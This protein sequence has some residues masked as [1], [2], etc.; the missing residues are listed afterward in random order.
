MPENTINTILKLKRGTDTSWA[1]SIEILKEGEPG[2]DKINNILKIGNG[3][4]IWENLPLIG[5]KPESFEQFS[6]DNHNALFSGYYNIKGSKYCHILG[7]IVVNNNYGSLPQSITFN[8]PV[9]IEANSAPN[10]IMSYAYLE[11]D[12]S[13]DNT[14]KRGT[15]YLINTINDRNI[16]QLTHPVDGQTIT[17]GTFYVD[18]SYNLM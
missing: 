14:I 2:Y 9:P 4:D 16:L 6:L 11:A 1:E 12:D 7:K 18:F 17:P 8:L 13:Q 15:L 5:D 3:I 10:P